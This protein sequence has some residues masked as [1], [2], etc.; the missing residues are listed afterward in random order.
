FG[1]CVADDDAGIEAGVFDQ[2]HGLGVTGNQ[3]CNIKAAAKDTAVRIAIAVQRRVGDKRVVVVAFE[4]D[5]S[6]AG[7]W[8]VVPDLPIQA[9]KSLWR[10]GV[11]SC[12]SSSDQAS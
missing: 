11:S 9:G 10:H 12:R 1:L 5:A 7:Q 6:G 4:P 8:N 2:Q 3:R